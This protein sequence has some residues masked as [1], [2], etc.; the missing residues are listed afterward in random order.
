MTI[1]FNAH[2]Y[3]SEVADI[4]AA[5]GDGRRTMP[6]AIAGSGCADAPIA[7]RGKRGK[8]V[9]SSSFAPEAALAGLWVYF[10]CFDEAHAIAQDLPSVEGSFWHGILHRQE[11]DPVNASY[12]FRRVGNHPVFP[13]LRAEIA[14]VLARASQPVNLQLQREWD[15]FAF[16]EFCESARKRPGSTDEQIAREIQLVEW[17]LLFDYCARNPER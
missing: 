5:D 4:L 9:F 12:W 11:P 2:A 6:L 15:P 8:S 10:S 3:G 13:Q 17:Q 1:V 7:L 16:I 14:A